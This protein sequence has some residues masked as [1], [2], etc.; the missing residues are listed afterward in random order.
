MDISGDG[1]TRQAGV[2]QVDQEQALGRVE[3]HHARTRAR[4]RHHW[5]LLLAGKR[6]R[7]LD[8][9]EADLPANL[10]AAIGR[11]VNVEVVET[12]LQFR[13]LRRRDVE[14]LRRNASGCRCRH[15]GGEVE[16]H[17]GVDSR[18]AGP[19]NVCGTRRGGETGEAQVDGDVIFGRAEQ[20]RSRPCPAAGDRRH[21]LRAGQRGREHLGPSRRRMLR[22]PED[23]ANRNR[24]PYKPTNTR[25]RTTNCRRE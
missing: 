11:R 18:C 6:R 8:G 1:A 23:H 22:G 3:S 15:D 10:A 21:L 16:Q 4:G 14:R 12:G 5:Y 17:T 19:V 7:V 9:R 24:E 13:D 25:T 2:T 20:D